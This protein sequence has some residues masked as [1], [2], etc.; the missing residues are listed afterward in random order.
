MPVEKGKNFEARD[1]YIDYPWA[2]V[3]FRWNHVTE[4]IF[5]CHYGDAESATPVAH[6]S[7]LFTE[8][9]LFGS[10]ISKEEY[11]RQANSVKRRF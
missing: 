1:V 11:E 2:N 6:D 10:E 9:T 4:Q 7:K 5:I 8:A 3:R